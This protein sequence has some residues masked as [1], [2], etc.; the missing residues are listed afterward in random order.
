MGKEEAWR[1]SKVVDL[2]GLGKCTRQFA[3]SAKKNAKCLLNLEK[4]ED[5]Y[6]ARNA[7]V[8]A[9]VRAVK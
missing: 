3:Q 5:L 4:A 6:Y 2:V 7:M 1:I 8:K 9:K